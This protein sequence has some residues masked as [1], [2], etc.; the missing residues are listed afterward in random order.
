MKEG[1]IQDTCAGF[2]SALASSAPVPGGGGAAAL[3]G[4]I[5]VALGNMVGS[6]TVGK[7]KYADV[8]EEILRLKARSDELQGALLALVERDAEA[9]APLARAYGL[10]TATEEE[11]SEKARVMAQALREAAQ[12]PLEIMELSVQALDA[13]DRFAQIG[14]RLAVSDAG[15]AAACCRAALCAASLNVAINTKAMEDRALA[16]E[17]DGRSEE[18]LR[19]GTE[20]ADAIFESVRAGLR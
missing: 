1:L 17:L 18:L 16:A 5:G 20:K 9:F 15:C 7:K 14:S 12:P 3:V 10:P 13:I 6:L 4:A 8:E 2:V 19:T 11:R